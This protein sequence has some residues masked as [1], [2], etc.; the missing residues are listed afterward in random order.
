MHKWFWLE[1]LKERPLGIHGR[2]WKENIKTNLTEI[3]AEDVEWSHVAQCRGQ[4]RTLAHK[5][6]NFQVPQSTENFLPTWGNINFSRRTLPY[7]VKPPSHA[8]ARTH[9]II[10]YQCS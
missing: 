10:H 1:T 9:F 5:V 2:P 7:R 8:R 6:M 3:A 4:W